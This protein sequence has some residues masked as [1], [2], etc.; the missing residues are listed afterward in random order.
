[1]EVNKGKGLNI[2]RTCWKPPDQLTLSEHGQ[3]PF[4]EEQF[5]NMLGKQTTTLHLLLSQSN[6]SLPAFEINHLECGGPAPRPEPGKLESGESL[7]RQD[8]QRDAPA[9]MVNDIL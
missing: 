8:S 2:V 5:K 6:T 7:N 1:M 4:M 3:T 9:L